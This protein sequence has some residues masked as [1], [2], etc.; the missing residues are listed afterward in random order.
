MSFTGKDDGDV[1]EEADEVVTDV[2]EEVE[3]AKINLELE[4]REQKLIVGDMRKLS[5]FY[6]ASGDSCLEKEGDLWMIACGRP[7]LVRYHLIIYI[8]LLSN[9]AKFF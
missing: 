7:M 1:E 3:L 8:S 9:L 5:C 2:I 4:E 6:D